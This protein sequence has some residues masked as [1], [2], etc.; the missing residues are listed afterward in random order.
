MS[1][2]SIILFFMYS[3]GLGYSLTFFFKNSE[4][5]F[6]RNLMRVGIGLGILPFLL[7]CMDF[8]YVPLDWR[9]LSAIVLIIPI[10]SA[11]KTYK[12]GFKIPVLSIKKSD[13][14]IFFVL[15]IFF[16][17][18][19]TY[20]KGAFNYP[21]FEDDDPWAHASSIK[22]IA[23]EKKIDDPNDTFKYI[24]P[25]PPGYDALMGILHQTSESLMWTM[26]FFNS[27]IIS[28]GLIFFYFFAR[29]FMKSNSGGLAAT[30]ILAMVPCYLS[31]FI[32]SHSLV[33]TILIISL[34]AFVMIEHDRKW[35][36]PSML[37]VGSAAVTQPSQSIKFFIIFIL[38]FLVKSI[39]N[40]KFHYTSFLAIFGG[41][42]I[43]LVWWAFNFREQFMRRA[44]GFF[45]Q[46][47]EKGNVISGFFERL[48]SL[49]TGG[50]A[51]RVYDLKDFLLLNKPGMKLFEGQNMIN[52]PVG[53]GII[54]SL[55]LLIGVAAIICSF[56]SMKKPKKEW[57]LIA[58]SWLVFTF[59]GINS[60]T[61]NLPVRLFAFRFW[62]LFAIP[63]SLI[64][65]E[66]F[67]FLINLT[68]KI[69]IPRIATVVVLVLAIFWTSGQQKYAVNTA[70]WGPGQMWTSGEEIQGYLWLK[71]L[72]A[73]TKVFSYSHD[74]QVIG[75][76]MFSCSWCDHVQ[77]FR[78]DL[79]Y[80]NASEVHNW[81]RRY[82]YEYLIVDGMAFRNLGRKFGEN[83][84]NELLPERY[85]EI[86]A[87][88]NFQKV[89][90]T[91]GMAVF[92]IA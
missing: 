64:A 53:V 66:G 71:N 79:L 36:I 91:G 41:Y 15:I 62:M 46:P 82:E 27:L 81:L 1:I 83:E 44:G 75:L 80:K 4:N 63:L 70:M 12:K 35:T 6:E 17:S 31:H 43:S 29:Q 19:F 77:E 78:S 42:F 60:L 32:W 21:Y 22:Y 72:P 28:L 11:Y 54:A 34:Y 38:F 16:F 65:A 14:Y 59:M 87:S 25:Y 49:N 48:S 39:L 61:F 5:F 8:L 73:N 51:D 92:R 76:D 26:K 69:G 84:T 37:L 74:E 45:E 52:N 7:V 47:I 56:K 55:L 18:L 2:I 57:A 85:E 86:S 50:T 40:K 88:S 23:V 68:R 24:E 10:Y 67:L 20:T 58:L 9:I 3:Y 33:I 90:Q 89:H 13:I 30:F